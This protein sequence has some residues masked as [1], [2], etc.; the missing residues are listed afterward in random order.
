MGLPSRLG[1]YDIEAELGRGA[2]GVV[3][4]AKDRT[5]R[6]EVALKVLPGE[7]EGRGLEEFLREVRAAARLRHP[8][9]VVVYGADVIDGHGV[10]ALELVEGGSLAEKLARHSPLP[11]REAVK[12]AADLASAVEAAHAQGI[13]HRD[14]KP[15]NVLLEKDGRPRLSDFGLARDARVR[16]LTATGDLV[17]TPYYMSPEQA[18][19]DVR[20]VGPWTDVWGLGAVFFECLT[21]VPPNEGKSAGEI[22]ARIV[23]PD[24]LSVNRVRRERGLEPLAPDLATISGKA[25]AKDPFRRY[26]TA[27]AFEE[28]LR[29]WLDGRP[30]VARPPTLVA[31]VRDAVTKR[32]RALVVGTALLLLAAIAAALVL[33][34]VARERSRRD[35]AAVLAR[36]GPGEGQLLRER[37][38]I[39]LTKDGDPDAVP[40]LVSALEA[41]TERI[42]AL[43]RAR[44]ARMLEPVNDEERARQDRIAALPQALERAAAARPDER[45]EL[46]LVRAIEEARRRLATRDAGGRIVSA[47]S[48]LA[49]A[50][51]AAVSEDERL[52]ALVA[53]EALGRLGRPEAALALGRFL[54]AE[55][56]D[57]RALAA[58]VALGRLKDAVAARCVLR[59]DDRPS[60]GGSLAS[61]ALA[62]LGHE[63]GRDLP[64]FEM[65]TALDF[66]D[67]GTLRALGSDDKG[68]LEDFARSI[69]LD[70]TDP[71]AWHGQGGVQANAGDF[72]SAVLSLARAVELDPLD[73]SRRA[74]LGWLLTR[75]GDPRRGLDECEKAVALDPFEAYAWSARGTVKLVGEDLDGALSDLSRSLELDP[76]AAGSWDNRASVKLARGDPHGALEDDSR[77]IALD[78]LLPVAWNNRALAK[79]KLHDRDG[80]IADLDRAIELRPLDA[81]SWVNR[82]QLRFERHDLA[83]AM[84][85]AT[86]SLEL[87][88]KSVRA[89]CVRARSRADRGDSSGARSD[90]LRAIEVGPDDFTAWNAWGN[91]CLSQGDKAEAL[92]SAERQLEISPGNPTALACR[93]TVKLQLGDAK[94]A[95]ADLLPTVDKTRDRPGAYRVLVEAYG[96]LGDAKSGLDMACRW[97]ELDPSSAEGWRH[98]AHCELLL[99]SL[100]AALA[101]GRRAVELDEH[102]MESHRLLAYIHKARGER[103]LARAEV[104]R[105]FDLVPQGADLS[106]LRALQREVEDM[107]Q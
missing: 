49:A 62:S 72:A 53:V 98:R 70:A 42:A 14:L 63:L 19:G 85:D 30:I 37:A 25:L 86:K 40:V 11:A 81:V 12:L 74:Y 83:L 66:L 17:G 39:E 84:A 101:S 92:H 67:R 52:R 65:K 9:I 27:A 97:V 23:G 55:E 103:D 46:P 54:H 73:A 22:L 10:V 45:I 28:D 26:R 56:S 69:A 5:L 18:R 64:P 3:Y 105:M 89:L 41:T 6:R 95:V 59:V 1:P 58:A 60:R 71:D 36:V 44:L 96:S 104:Q 91:F 102:D 8:G 94:G 88:P 29:R 32:V 21:G 61:R 100:D 90:L 34:L 2:M 7:A 4:R 87:D 47:A 76:L 82:A 77:A 38:V 43:S 33:P 24:V 99:K 35:H 16:S 80:A 106:G 93:A 107:G 15:A 50:Q 78:P 79:V 68:A 75:R 20:A 13:I 51:E 31:R 48:I 57:E